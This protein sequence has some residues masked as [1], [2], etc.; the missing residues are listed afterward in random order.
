VYVEGSEA[1]ADYRQQLLTWDECLPRLPA[2]CQ[3]LQFATTATGFVTAL[4]ERL[5]E[6][7][8]RVDAAYPANTA[9]TIDAEGT[10]H[11]KRLSAQPL[12]DDLATLEALGDFSKRISLF[13]MLVLG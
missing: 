12:P 1:Y 8:Q 3:A 13:R 6:V 11:L 9:L 7:A 4:R 5:R 10:P 2:S